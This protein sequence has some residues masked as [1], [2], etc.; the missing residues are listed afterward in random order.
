MVGSKLVGKKI[1]LWRG[2][3]L[4]DRTFIDTRISFEEKLKAIISSVNN[5][6][7]S[8]QLIDN[9][10]CGYFGA[11]G[12]AVTYW[13]MVGSKLVGKKISNKLNMKQENGLIYCIKMKEISIQPRD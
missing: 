2:A 5:K 3:N 6:A 12:R 13:F 7:L 1:V 10:L 4:P 9:S 11:Y 8:T